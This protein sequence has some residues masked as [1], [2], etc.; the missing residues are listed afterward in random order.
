MRKTKK[1]NKAWILHF[2]GR[3]GDLMFAI[4]VALILSV[5]VQQPVVTVHVVGHP[6][7]LTHELVSVE[8]AVVTMLWAGVCFIAGC[9]FDR[10]GGKE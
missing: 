3:L 4:A 5:I 2:L 9:L 1:P 7:Y 6:A 10:L 8:N